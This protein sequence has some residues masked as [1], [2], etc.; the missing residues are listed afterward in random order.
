MLIN[1]SLSEMEMFSDE[2]KQG[3]N[4]IGMSCKSIGKEPPKPRL[5][6]VNRNQMRL[7]P[8]EVEKLVSE[9]HE[10]RAI[11]ELVGRLDLSRYYES[12][13][14]KEGIAGRPTYDP[15]LLISIWIYSYSKGI[16]SAREIARLCEYDP[17]YQWF[18]GM[19][20]INYHTLSDFRVKHREAMERVFVEILGVLSSEGLVTLERV[21]HDGTKVKANAS[22][23]TF[24]KEERITKH[25]EIAKEQIKHIAEII[26]NIR[27]MQMIVKRVALNRNVVPRIYQ[28][29]VQS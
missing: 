24:R 15:Q 23:D 6:M 28:K 8:V 19:D 22:G 12:I 13:E 18:T 27:Q 9:D 14:A 1:K 21:M 26:I 29:D 3:I 17:A 4:C 16:G 2:F 20:I 10:V 5:L 25:L 11:W 7:H